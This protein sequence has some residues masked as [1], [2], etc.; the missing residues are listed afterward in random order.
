MPRMW[1][2]PEVPKAEEEAEPQPPSLPPMLDWKNQVFI[3]D[4][5]CSWLPPPTLLALLCLPEAEEAFGEYLDEE[6][7]DVEDIVVLIVAYTAKKKVGGGE[8]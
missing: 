8:S 2:L 4:P 7:E 6:D 5:K 1:S 3:L